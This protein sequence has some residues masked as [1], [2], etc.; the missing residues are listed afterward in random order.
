M[1]CFV[2]IFKALGYCTHFLFYVIISPVLCGYFKYL[3]RT[4]ILYLL[5][6]LSAALIVIALL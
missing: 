6:L 5:L 1:A 3:Y 4:V 2:N